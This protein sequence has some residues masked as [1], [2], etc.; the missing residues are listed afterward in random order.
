MA[1]PDEAAATLAA[2]GSTLPSIA[3]AMGVG[4]WDDDTVPTGQWVFTCTNGNTY[5]Y[6]NPRANDWT[7]A[8]ALVGLN[9]HRTE[10]HVDI[11]K[12]ADR[13]LAKL[14]EVS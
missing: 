9:A 3:E 4:L 12:A 13:L 6:R 14:S 2:L 7:L 10:Q 8:A 11:A 1:T 5:L